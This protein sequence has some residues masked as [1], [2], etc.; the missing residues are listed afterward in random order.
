VWDTVRDE[1]VDTVL[2]HAPPLFGLSKEELRRLQFFAGYAPVIAG[3]YNRWA[4]NRQRWVQ[5]L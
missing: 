4:F 2:Q 3:F 1:H 5:S